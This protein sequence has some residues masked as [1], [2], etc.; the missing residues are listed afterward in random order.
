[1]KFVLLSWVSFH[2]FCMA[3]LNLVL[4]EI[5]V[6]SFILLLYPE[7]EASTS[8]EAAHLQQGNLTVFGLVPCNIFLIGWM[9]MLMS[10]F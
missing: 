10:H 6:S 4:F 8:Y 3:I 2:E 5:F 9:A 1:M 7:V